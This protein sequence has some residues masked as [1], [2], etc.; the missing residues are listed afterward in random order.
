MYSNFYSVLQ[1]RILNVRKYKILVLLHP[2]L[3]YSSRPMHYISLLQKLVGTS[4][5]QTDNS[6]RVAGAANIYTSQLST[7]SLDIHTSATQ[8]ALIITT[9][10]LPTGPRTAKQHTYKNAGLQ[11]ASISQS[12][13]CL[14]R[15]HQEIITA[16]TV[17]VWAAQQPVYPWPTADAP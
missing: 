8:L 3:A 4:H 1:Q 5:S 9:A 15:L 10:P 14:R 11:Q 2:F 7:C 17:L 13:L 6:Y 16:T 12:P